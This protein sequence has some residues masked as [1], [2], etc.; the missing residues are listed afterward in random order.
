MRF[1][2]LA[3][4]CLGFGYVLIVGTHFIFIYPDI[5]EALEVIP[6]GLLIIFSFWAY[7]RISEASEERLD[8]WKYTDSLKDAIENI[9][10]KEKEGKNKK[11]DTS[12]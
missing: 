11:D 8:I 7:N 10:K 9:E 5:S 3:G 12:K 4:I 2:S 6:I 1:L